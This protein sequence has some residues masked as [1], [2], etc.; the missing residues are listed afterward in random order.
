MIADALREE[1]VTYYGAQQLTDSFRTVR[2]NTIRVAQDIPED[3][4][5]HTP[6]DGARTVAQM[7]VHVA[8]SPRLFWQAPLES[9]IKDFTTFDF[10]APTRELEREES[11]PRSKDEIVNLLTREGESFARFLENRSEA[12]LSELF[13]SPMSSGQPAMKSGLE[14]LLGAK[15]HE[16][17]HRAQLML[18]ER[19]L[20]II[21]HLTRQMNAMMEQMTPKANSV[22]A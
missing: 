11:A 16:M 13:K 8:C 19:Q 10:M 7:L 1:H 5:S 3:K 4:Y 6:A 17:H 12:E 18:V 20:G 2:K 14:L 21:P 22:G 9:G 15:E